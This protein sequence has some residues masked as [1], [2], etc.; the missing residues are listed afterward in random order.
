MAFTLAISGSGVWVITM[1]SANVFQSEFKQ[2][3]PAAS[4]SATKR[5]LV[6]CG[7]AISG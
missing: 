1:T 2:G 6:A 5:R 4:S 3:H 7:K